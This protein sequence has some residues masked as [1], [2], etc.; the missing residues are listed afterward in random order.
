MQTNERP[1]T[2][3]EGGVEVCDYGVGQAGEVVSREGVMEL[4]RAGNP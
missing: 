3:W 2:I 4:V 1:I